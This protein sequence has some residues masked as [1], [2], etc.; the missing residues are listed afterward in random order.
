[1]V[2]VAS[3]QIAPQSATAIAFIGNNPFGSQLGTPHTR[4]GHG[5]L[6]HQGVKYDRF[7][8]FAHY[9]QKGHQFT[10]TFDPQMNL[11]TESTFR[12]KELDHHLSAASIILDI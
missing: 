1:M 4:P 7:V 2:N 5:T 8:A 11:R 9:Q 3:V 6:G 12:L 10:L